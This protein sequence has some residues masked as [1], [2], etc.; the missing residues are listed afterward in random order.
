MI[1]FAWLYFI[2]KCKLG[3]SFK[4]VGR[5]TLRLFNKLYQCYKDNFDMEMR[6]KISNTTYADIKTKLQN[7]DKWF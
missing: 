5:L 6:L 2:G 4:E 1:D 3:L 7:Q